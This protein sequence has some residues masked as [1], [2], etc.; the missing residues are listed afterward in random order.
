MQAENI[1]AH[2]SKNEGVSFYI[3]QLMI[4]PEECQGTL[5]LNKHTASRKGTALLI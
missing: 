4:L 3:Q 5:S 1:Q 2:S